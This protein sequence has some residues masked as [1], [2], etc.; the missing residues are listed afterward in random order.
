MLNILLSENTISWFKP[1]TFGL[2]VRRS[3]V[4]RPLS[5][6]GTGWIVGLIC[7]SERPRQKPEIWPCNRTPAMQM[8][9]SLFERKIRKKRYFSLADTDFSREKTHTVFTIPHVSE[10]SLKMINRN[11]YHT[12]W[13][14]KEHDSS[15]LEFIWTPKGKYKLKAIRFLSGRI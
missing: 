15:S 14:F 9:L 5:A 10:Y 7:R 13:N 4:P 1:T 6:V 8:R 2:P 12:E 3:L 11:C